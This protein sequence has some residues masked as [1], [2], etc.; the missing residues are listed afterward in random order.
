MLNKRNRT[1][2]IIVLIISLMTAVLVRA[3]QNDETIRVN[4]QFDLLV[5]PGQE[6]TYR[7]VLSQAGSLLGRRSFYIAGRWI[8]GDRLLRIAATRESEPVLRTV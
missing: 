5:P 8:N 2:F 1:A 6:V 3:G 4:R 7:N